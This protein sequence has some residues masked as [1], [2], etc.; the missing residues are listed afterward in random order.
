MNDKLDIKAW[1]EEYTLLLE[2]DDKLDETIKS[3]KPSIGT[4][5]LGDDD[6]K[7]AFLKELYNKPYF[8]GELDMLYF[9]YLNETGTYHLF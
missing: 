6:A 7:R 3:L 5:T 1:L 4:S 2:R 9:N 8:K